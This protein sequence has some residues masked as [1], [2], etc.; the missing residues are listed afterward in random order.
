[1]QTR[2]R[3]TAAVLA[4]TV[5]MMAL[6]GG[7]REQ[8][9]DGSSREAPIV[10]RFWNGFTGPDGATMERLVRSFNASHP[11]IRVE[12]QIIPW[13]TYYD[14]LTLGLAYGDPPD[15]FILHTNRFPEYAHYEA[16]EGLDSLV[17]SG[18]LDPADFI[19]GP[20]MAGRWKGRQFAIPLDCHPQ[21]LYYNTEL[22]EKAGIVD[23]H[24]RARPPRDLAEFIDAA[25]RLTVDADGDG[26]PEQWGFAFTWLRT[27]AYTFLNQ[28]GADVL[29][30]GLRRSG[31]SDPRAEEALTLMRRLIAEYRV[32]P[33]PE[34]QDSWVGFQTGRVAMALEGVYMLTSLQE[35]KNLRFAAAPAPLF[36]RTP[37]VWGGS[38]LMCMPAGIPEERRRAAWTFVRFLSDRSLEW[39][40][41]GQVPVRRS[42]LD[43]P[44]FRRLEVQYQFSR[45]LDYVVNEPPSVMYNQIVP[46]LDAAVEAI[47]T[48][49]LPPR[50]ALAEATRRIEAVL[51]RQ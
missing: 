26:K 22:F 45:Q 35:Q 19:E 49:I 3:Q 13:G 32:C 21:G 7:C 42:I 11:G 40:A 50:E 46:F 29:K 12:M 41:G 36:G 51:E 2:I 23:E 18:G 24:G 9:K 43:T 15:V 47:L 1:M 39:A 20:W 28:F 16:L 25:R 37:A 38:H 8:G 27:N 31:L 48:G 14:K 10:I 6:A 34:G 17:A 30:P 44:E 33:S 5:A 4:A